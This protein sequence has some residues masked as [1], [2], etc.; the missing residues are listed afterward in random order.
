LPDGPE[1]PLVEIQE[2]ENELVIKLFNTD[3]T[4]SYVE[5][6]KNED[7]DTIEYKFQGYMIYQLK[8]GSVSNS[9]LE[10]IEKA[11]LV[12][13]C[14]VKDNITT[15]INLEY[16][17]D[18]SANVPKLKVDGANL[19]INHTFSIKEDAFAAGSNKNLVNYKT[20]N[21]LIVAYG[22][23]SNDP[24]KLEP[25]QFLAGRNT[26]K[27]SGYPHKPMSE[28]GGSMLQA[29]YGDGPI[30]K[31]IS[32]RGNGGMVLEFTK[33]TID[34]ILR[35]GSDPQPVYLGGAGPVN[36]KVVDPT[37]VPKA[38]FEFR[39]IEPDSVKVAASGNVSNPYQ[40]SISQESYWVLTNLTSGES[41]YAD[42]TIESKIET[43]QGKVSLGGAT[44]MVNG[45]K[46][47]GLAVEVQQVPA[48]GR[49]PYGEPTNGFV[50]FDVKFADDNQR[51]LTAVID[52]DIDYSP[53]NWIRSG[54]NGLASS[55]FNGYVNDFYSDF[56]PNHTGNDAY[57]PYE[58]F[59]KIWDRR[60]APYAL[61]AREQGPHT[62][63][64]IIYAP[65]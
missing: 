9:D 21:Y 48:P 20:Y 2:L 44:K 11:R 17:A 36:I 1:P 39:F 16:D 27:L 23:P 37:L 50:S 3:Q 28:Q 64:A 13:Q 19:G 7:N 5:D 35:N 60:I 22:Y 59:E 4:E 45:L 56:D 34:N 14:D 15:M 47:W 29:G 30:L 18:V 25:V 6:I 10:D 51:W 57:D 42:G 38:N 52:A 58:V 31:Q 63:G 61:C 8:D 26:V 54:T 32:G 46:D 53:F 43:I 41:V 24:Q 33:E 65:A 12:R 55:T 62:N 49:N 40:D